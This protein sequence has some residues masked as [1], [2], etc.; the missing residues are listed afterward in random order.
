MGVEAREYLEM[1]LEEEIKKEEDKETKSKEVARINFMLSAICGQLKDFEDARTYLLDAF[2]KINDVNE[3]NGKNFLK[4]IGKENLNLN[5]ELGNFYL[6]EKKFVEAGKYL[7]MALKEE[8]K[9]GEDK[10]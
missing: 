9:K 7:Q 10:E 3:D 2:E 6:A 4:E 1:A 8:I 5:Y